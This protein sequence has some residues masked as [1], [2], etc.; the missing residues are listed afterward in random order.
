M[1]NHSFLLSFELAFTIKSLIVV[2]FVIGIGFLKL[3]VGNDSNCL[4]QFSGGN[5]IFGDG[6]NFVLEVYFSR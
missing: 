3:Y 6:R 1:L 4:L 2:S 5:I